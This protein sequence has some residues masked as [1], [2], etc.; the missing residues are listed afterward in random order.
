MDGL[1]GAGRGSGGGGPGNGCPERGGE[2]IDTG[3]ASLEIETRAPHECLETLL[4][5]PVF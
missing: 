1:G 5:N 2:L 4:E 3:M